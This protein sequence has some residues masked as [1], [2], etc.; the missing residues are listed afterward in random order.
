MSKDY[1]TGDEQT[2]ADRHVAEIYANGRHYT[3]I[4]HV[5]VEQQQKLR[6][7]RG[8]KHCHDCNG[9]CVKD[10]TLCALCRG[11]GQVPDTSC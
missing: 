2:A 10:G 7:F 11:N 5:F 6:L 8:F 9:I 3:T 4:T 1:I